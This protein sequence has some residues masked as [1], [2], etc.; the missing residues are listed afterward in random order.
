MRAARAA[1]TVMDTPWP[2]QYPPLEWWTT[3]LAGRWPE[4]TGPK[5]QSSSQSKTSASCSTAPDEEVHELAEAGALY[6]G[7][8]EPTLGSVLAYLT[9]TSRAPAWPWWYRCGGW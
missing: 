2:D 9:A 5:S 1:T 7:D 4:C 6:A 3:P 8:G